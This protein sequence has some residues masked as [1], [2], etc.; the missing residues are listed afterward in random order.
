[1]PQV[2][3]PRP[4]AAGVAHVGV[5]IGGDHREP[6]PPVG[7]GQRIKGLFVLQRRDQRAEG[8]KGNAGIIQAHRLHAQPVVSSHLRGGEHD[9]LR[10]HDAL[11]AAEQIP[12][13]GALRVGSR[14]LHGGFQL[15]GLHGSQRPVGIAHDDLLVAP[16][17]HPA[18]HALDNIRCVFRQN[19]FQRKEVFAV[20][21]AL[22]GDPRVVE[23]VQRRDD[24]P[25]DA[26]IRAEALPV[27]G[28]P[29]V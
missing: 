27:G 21:G 12:Q 28:I 2:L 20:P 16:L 7:K 23:L 26:D 13:T 9:L 19:L 29:P 24:L 22:H 3:Y 4:Q 18:A 14:Q 15:V 1:M 5:G 10:A 17:L 11:I 6:F 25:D 8:V